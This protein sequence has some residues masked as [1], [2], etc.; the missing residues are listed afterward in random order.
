[1]ARLP[2]PRFR[3]CRRFYTFRPVLTELL[4]SSELHRDPWEPQATPLLAAIP[5][6]TYVE[7]FYPDREPL[8]WEL[9]AN[10]PAS[11]D[12]RWSGMGNRARSKGHRKVSLVVDRNPSGRLGAGFS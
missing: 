4:G 8:F 10:Q 7:C 12:S 6:G 11:K 2:V 1:M 9:I 5:N 3:S